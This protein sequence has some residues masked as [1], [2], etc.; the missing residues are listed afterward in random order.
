MHTYTDEEKIE[1]EN[2]E[3]YIAT[4]VKLLKE[5]KS[6]EE[7]LEFA[8][9]DFEEGLIQNKR[10]KLSVKIKSLSAKLREI[11]SLEKMA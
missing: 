1:L 6:H 5:Y 11:E 8:D 9:D 7:D 10:D 3:E 2:K 4:K